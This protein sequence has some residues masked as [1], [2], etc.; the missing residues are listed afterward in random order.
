M[1]LS[2]QNEF[3]VK[4]NKL[5]LSK[6]NKGKNQGYKIN[7]NCLELDNQDRNKLNIRPENVSTENAPKSP[8]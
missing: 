5:I 8:S 4:S 6:S 7:F 3:R 2:E 1:N